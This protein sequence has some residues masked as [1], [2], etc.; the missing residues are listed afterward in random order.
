MYI[1]SLTTTNIR[2]HDG[3]ETGFGVRS[4]RRNRPLLVR[5]QD[6]RLRD[7]L[8]DFVGPISFGAIHPYLER[9][10]HAFQNAPTQNEDWIRG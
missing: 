9:A 10:S 3:V 8:F 5:L 6:H 4:R 7:C 1:G 2:K